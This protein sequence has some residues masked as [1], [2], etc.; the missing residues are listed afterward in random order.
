MEPLLNTA[1]HRP[2]PEMQYAPDGHCGSLFFTICQ[3]LP[4]F[5]WHWS[6]AVTVGVSLRKTLVSV[7]KYREL[8][9]A[10]LYR[11]I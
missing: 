7:R 5:G 6:P 11:M 8:L 3:E 4:G 2:Q 10:V 1:E 9:N